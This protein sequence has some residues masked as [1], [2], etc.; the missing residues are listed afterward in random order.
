[1][2]PPCAVSQSPCRPEPDSVQHGGQNNATVDV[3]CESV[4]QPRPCCTTPRPRDSLRAKAVARSSRK[5][6]TTSHG[7]AWATVQSRPVPSPLYSTSCRTGTVPQHT[8]MRQ[9]RAAASTPCGPGTQGV[10]IT[11]PP[12]HPADR[13]RRANA[14]DRRQ[15]GFTRCAC[16]F[17]SGG[18]RGQLRSAAMPRDAA[19]GSKSNRTDG[20]RSQIPPE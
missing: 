17:G 11:L 1:M 12:P 2:S 20:T 10:S 15:V 19:F 7:V 16:H 4:P 18:R 9:Y 5:C 13:G 6:P 14:S 3:S 8:C